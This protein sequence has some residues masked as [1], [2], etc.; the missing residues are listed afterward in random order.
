[1][2]NALKYFLNI[3]NDESNK[4]HVLLILKQLY[5]IQKWCHKQKYFE[6]YSSSILIVYDASILNNTLN[7]PNSDWVRVKMIDFAHV[8][9]IENKSRCDSNYIFGINKLVQMFESFV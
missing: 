5:K 1:M 3:Q 2:P 4:V 6:L 8:F 7:K 9:P